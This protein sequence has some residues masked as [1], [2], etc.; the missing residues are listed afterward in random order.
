MSLVFPSLFAWILIP[1]QD[2]QLA[3]AKSSFQ[4]EQAA[5]RAVIH[6]NLVRSMTTV[7][8]T[9][10]K[11]FPADEPPL[12]PIDAMEEVDDD[13][14][15][16]RQSILPPS[17]TPLTEV[18]R[19][20][21]HR[22]APLRRVQRTLERTLGAASSE[23]THTGTGSVAPWSIGGKARPREFAVTSRSGWKAALSRVRSGR[24]SIDVGSDDGSRAQVRVL[25]SAIGGV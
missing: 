17:T 7:M 8:N 6:L 18:H 1:P 4:A 9:L 19:A 14:D 23:E 12:T 2:F 21:L 5:W 13:D 24:G 16:D 20:Q 11:E 10:V 3:Y 15:A 25:L 22:L